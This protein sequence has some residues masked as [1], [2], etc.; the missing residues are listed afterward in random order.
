L[1]ER[2]EGKGR[3]ATLWWTNKRDQKALRKKTGKEIKGTVWKVGNASSNIME[4]I[5]SA[6]RNILFAMET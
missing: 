2:E 1:K 5:Q 3:R 4:E 6:I